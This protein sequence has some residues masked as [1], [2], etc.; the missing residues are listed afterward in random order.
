MTLVAPCVELLIE[1][2]A[3]IV[4]VYGRE[5]RVYYEG[6]DFKRVLKDAEERYVKAGPLISELNARKLAHL[7]CRGL[8]NSRIGG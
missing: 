6:V 2:A 5:D 1:K 7:I 4:Y 8:N 3:A